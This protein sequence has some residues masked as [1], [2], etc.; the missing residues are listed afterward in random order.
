MRINTNCFWIAQRLPI[1]MGFARCGFQ[2]VTSIPLGG[3]DEV[4]CLIDFG[5]APE[6]VLAGLSSLKELKDATKREKA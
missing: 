6:I 4:A 2:N 5:L 3:V 1:R